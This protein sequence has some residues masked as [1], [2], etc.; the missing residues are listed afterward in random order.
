MEEH[1]R[2]L[3]GFP[4]RRSNKWVDGLMQITSDNS[5]SIANSAK[6][7]ERALKI[8]VPML[9][10]GLVFQALIVAHSYG[11]DTVVGAIRAALGHP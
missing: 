11:G 8:G 3:N 2:L 5:Q 6:T 7:M 9:A 1:D 4:D 10:L